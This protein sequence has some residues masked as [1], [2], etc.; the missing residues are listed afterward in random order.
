MNIK[1]GF[2]MANCNYFKLEV[3]GMILPEIYFDYE[4]AKAALR[5]IENNNIAVISRVIVF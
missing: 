4:K 2:Y 1:K 3:N 5:D